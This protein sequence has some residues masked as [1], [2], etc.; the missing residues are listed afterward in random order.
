MMFGCLDFWHT[1]M[2]DDDFWGQVTNYAAMI[3]H[4]LTDGEDQ[5]TNPA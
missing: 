5:D 3:Q 2:D 4:V 1:M